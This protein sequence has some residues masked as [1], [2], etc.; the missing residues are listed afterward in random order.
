MFIRL[1]FFSVF[2]ALISIYFNFAKYSQILTYI[3]NVFGGKSNV[4]LFTKDEL[5]KYNGV[6]NPE[7][8]LAIL[9]NVYNVTKGKNFYGPGQSYEFFVGQLYFEKDILIK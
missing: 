5:K 8:Y 3:Q 2:I 9:G 7:L 6:G 4:M 1:V